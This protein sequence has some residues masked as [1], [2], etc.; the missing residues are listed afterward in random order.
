MLET[1]G[2]VTQKKLFARIR[3]PALLPTFPIIK[4]G[5]TNI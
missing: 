1:V 4:P 5:K 3:P 2:E